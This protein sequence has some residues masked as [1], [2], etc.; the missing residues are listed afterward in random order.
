MHRTLNFYRCLLT[1]THKIALVHAQIAPCIS[2]SVFTPSQFVLAT[3][4]VS[5]GVKPFL[6]S[7]YAQ[8]CNRKISDQKQ[9][10]FLL[11]TTTTITTAV[12][13]SFFCRSSI[14]FH[15]VLRRVYTA[16]LPVLLSP[17]NLNSAYYSDGDR[18]RPG[19]GQRNNKTDLPTASTYFARPAH[20]V[21]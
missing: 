21:T 20:E 4:C 13:T 18:K 3:K 6:I 12:S 8:L 16:A 1:F 5:T 15:Q 14:S 9:R 17:M 7:F 19:A 2:L 11:L 10:F